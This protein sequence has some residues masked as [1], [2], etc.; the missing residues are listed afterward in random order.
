MDF[1]AVDFVEYIPRPVVDLQADL[2]LESKA[3]M[4][5]KISKRTPQPK[6]A[7]SIP[8]SVVNEFGITSKTMQAFEVCKW[9]LNSVLTFAC[10]GLTE[11]VLNCLRRHRT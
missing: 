4:K 10:Q 11:F 8:E 5:K 1:T 3:D 9:Q 6:P 7:Q 2:G